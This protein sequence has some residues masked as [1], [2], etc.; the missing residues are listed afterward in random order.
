MRT[1]FNFYVNFFFLIFVFKY[2]THNKIQ[3]KIT[4]IESLWVVVNV[5]VIA[6]TPSTCKKTNYNLYLIFI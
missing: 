4:I 1:I 5:N 6:I 3:L 2:K